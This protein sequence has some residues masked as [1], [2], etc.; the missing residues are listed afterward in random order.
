MI[1]DLS[2]KYQKEWADGLCDALMPILEIAN[3]YYSNNMDDEARRYWGENYEHENKTPPENI[4]LVTGRGGKT[5]LTLGDCLRISLI[6]KMR[7]LT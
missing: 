3:A 6:L 4:I 2:C 5:L 7:D 1:S